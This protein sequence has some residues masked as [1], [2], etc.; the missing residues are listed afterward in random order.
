MTTLKLLF[1]TT[2]SEPFGELEIGFETTRLDS[3][4]HALEL[5]RLQTWDIVLIASEPGVLR[6]ADWS[7]LFKVDE[8]RRHI[9]IFLW[10]CQATADELLELGPKS[11]H[12]TPPE[13]S[14][15]EMLEQMQSW[16]RTLPTPP[17]EVIQV[18]DLILDLRARAAAVGTAR[19]ILTRIEFDLLWCLATSA[20][21]VVTREE[22]KKTVW[23]ESIETTHSR[24]IDVHVRALRKKIPALE[25]LIHSIYG[26]GYRLIRTAISTEIE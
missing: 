24:T 23:R 5:A 15:T 14:A 3:A 21:Q 20:N 7:R 13:A 2:S 22:I 12:F 11:V 17:L 26:V 16:V 9:P 1:I 19:T 18:G 6:A 10:G 8:S 25:T 4:V